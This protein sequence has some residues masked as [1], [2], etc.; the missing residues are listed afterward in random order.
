MANKL[1]E[2]VTGARFD[3]KAFREYKARVA[4][5][6]VPYATSV[7]AIERY[8]MYAGGVSDGKTMLRMLDDLAALFEAAAADATPVRQVV[9]DDPVEFVEDFLRNYTDGH[10]LS[11][12]RAKLIATIETA[13]ASQAD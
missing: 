9:G 13:E 4:N 11:K 6:P 3:K 2:L 8:L 7:A 1:I 10:W 12:E 5:L